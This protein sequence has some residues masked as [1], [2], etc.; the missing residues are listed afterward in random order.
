MNVMIPGVRQH[1]SVHILA[2]IL[3]TLVVILTT[4]PIQENYFLIDDFIFLKD[5]SVSQHDF[6]HIFS[7]NHNFVRSL[8]NLYFTF[9]YAVFGTDPVGYYVLNVLQHSLA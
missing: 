2:L 7:L 5:A 1:I 9:C 3:I 8:T 4:G 6:L